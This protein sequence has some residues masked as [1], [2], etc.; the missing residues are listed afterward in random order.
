M[1]SLAVRSEIPLVVVA[2]LDRAGGIGKNGAIPWRL[3]AD[4]AF[5]K[6]LTTSPDPTAVLREHGLSVEGLPP[7]LFPAA[8]TPPPAAGGPPN[9]VIMGR[10]TWD[11]LPAKWQPLPGRLNLILSHSPASV[12]KS[13]G[14][15][16]TS[17][18]EALAEAGRSAAPHIFVIGGGAVY[19]E[20]LQ[21]PHCRLLVLTRVERDFECNVRFP[22]IPTG[23]A[24]LGSSPLLKEEGFAFRLELMV[25]R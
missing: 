3:R 9:A 5:F 10:K 16:V 13:G 17:W 7:G 19:R 18:E 14:Q 22:A 23:F 8:P 25:R 11:S 20:A 2:A 24:T 4:L 1:T 15:W 21:L 12:P 6:A